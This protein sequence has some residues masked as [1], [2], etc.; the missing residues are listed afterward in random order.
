MDIFIA[1]IEYFTKEAKDFISAIAM[2]SRHDKKVSKPIKDIIY[3]GLKS[4]KCSPD[5]SNQKAGTGFST[6]KMDLNDYMI[7]KGA[8]S[9]W[10][11]RRIDDIIEKIIVKGASKDRIPQEL[12]DEYNSI[13]SVAKYD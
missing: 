11:D 10:R 9:K 4:C 7:A 2:N 12:V 13:V 5:T 1:P 6:E 3:I 8:L